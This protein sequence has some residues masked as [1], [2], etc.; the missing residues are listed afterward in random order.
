MADDLDRVV[1]DFVR[2]NAT[3]RNAPEFVPKVKQVGRVISIGDG[4]AHVEGLRDIAADELVAFPND[5]MAIASSIKLDRVG[6]I[7]LGDASTL[8]VGAPAK[9][10][11]RVVDVPVGDAFQGRIVDALGRPLDGKG[12]VRAAGREPVEKPACRNSRTSSSGASARS[13]HTTKAISPIAPITRPPAAVPN[14]KNIVSELT[15]L[16]RSC[17]LARLTTSAI[18]DG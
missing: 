17:S 1:H 8:S 12:P 4:V 6:L 3:A 11:Q 15:A 5:L 7:L 18:S 9:R 13:S 10:T 16:A 14:S 2:A